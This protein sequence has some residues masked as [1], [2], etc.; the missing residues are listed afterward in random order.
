[1]IDFGVDVDAIP[2]TP[3]QI[4]K[5]FSQIEFYLKYIFPFTFLYLSIKSNFTI[6]FSKQNY[7]LY[8]CIYKNPIILLYKLFFISVINKYIF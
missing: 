4:I 2:D 7:M 3:T 6:Y 1:M 8:Y 5:I